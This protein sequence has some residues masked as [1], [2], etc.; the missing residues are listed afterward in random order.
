MRRLARSEAGVEG[1][2]AGRLGV[3]VEAL[4]AS[5]QELQTLMLLRH[6]KVVLE[7]EWAPYR[8]TDRHALYS[9]SKSFTSM[10]VGLA[11]E[12]G[13][14]GLDDQVV[15]FFGP[16]DL[17]AEISDN[18]AAMR[19]R[20]LLTMT[21]GHTEDVV[22]A[23][24]DTPRRQFLA[25]EVAE[26]PGTLFVYNTG[27]TFML[28]AILQRVTGQ[29]LLDY[30]KPRLFEPIGATEARWQETPDGINTGGWGLELN[31]ESVAVFG[32]LLLDRGGDVIPAHWVEAATS[33]Q[34]PNDNQDNP[35]WRKGY[36]FQFWRSRHNSYRADGAFGQFLVVLPEQDAVLVITSAAP[37]MQAV[38]EVIW[39]HL[40][41]ALEG[42]DDGVY[43]PT[44]DF[45]L[46]PPSLG[47]A[48]PGDGTTYVFEANQFGLLTARLDRDGSGTFSF[49]L[50]ATGTV[51]DVVCREGDWAETRWR[52]GWLGDRLLTSATGDP[53][54]ASMR[55]AETPQLYTLTCRPDGDTITVDIHVNVGFG[56]ADTTLIGRAG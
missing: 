27:A 51:Q 7:Q 20:D 42:P 38:L 49:D 29:K 26:K 28:S 10:G 56:P 43:A 36:G 4:A 3:F 18:L 19:V 35:D 50:G 2:G 25:T 1:V 34:V 55:F 6:G 24:S 39:E 37:N 5:G 53:F 12:D 9:I 16:A 14:L 45:D 52:L 33:K 44:V 48:A 54:T 13:L 15:S 47:K 32:Q 46:K 41:P 22:V 23:G 30:L 21:T 31:T 11:I 40:L 17:P 8:I